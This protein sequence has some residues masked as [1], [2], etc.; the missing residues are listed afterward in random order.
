MIF[1]GKQP[2]SIRYPVGTRVNVKHAIAGNF[3]T[4]TV[5]GYITRLGDERYTIETDTGTITPMVYPESITMC[6]DFTVERAGK[7]ADS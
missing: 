2:R 4:G 5:T 6:N 7:R 1:R 3:A